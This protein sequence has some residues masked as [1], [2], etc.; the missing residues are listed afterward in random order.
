MK[1]TRLRHAS[2]IGWHGE[3]PVE[4]WSIMIRYIP[5]T[6]H[7]TL[8]LGITL[9]LLAVCKGMLEA[10]MDTILAYLADI[11]TSCHTWQEI[12]NKTEPGKKYEVVC[13][14]WQFIGELE[15]KRGTCHLTRYIRF[16]SLDRRYQT[17]EHL[18]NCLSLIHY[19]YLECSYGRERQFRTNDTTWV[20]KKFIRAEQVYS[21]RGVF[22][23]Q[24][25]NKKAVVLNRMAE[26]GVYDYISYEE[27]RERTYQCFLKQGFGDEDAIAVAIAS[28]T[29]ENAVV[30]F[31]DI[32]KEEEK[33]K[34]PNEQTFKTHKA[35][36]TDE[37]ENIIV[38]YK[39]ERYHIHSDALKDFRARC[40][41]LPNSTCLNASYFYVLSKSREANL[42]IINHTQRYYIPSDI[43]LT[44]RKDSPLITLK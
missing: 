6:S 10:L 20:T 35:R 16:C 2:S 4:I 34:P 31:F 5:L 40:F 19:C 12:A 3:V 22:Y 13:M 44:G 26:V 37:F 7:G 18:S 41:Y 9:R 23:F 21:L 27:I 1:R 29:E 43:S 36:V 42:N 17:V 11:M 38:T 28:S 39:N 33:E 8:D 14:I 25:T 15:K 24:P 30:Q 32:I